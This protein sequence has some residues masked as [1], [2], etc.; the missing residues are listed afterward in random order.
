MRPASARDYDVYTIRFPMQLRVHG[1]GLRQT[2]D[3]QIVEIAVPNDDSRLHP[4]SRR[5]SQ[6]PPC[7]TTTT[8]NGVTDPFVDISRRST[9]VSDRCASGLSRSP[10]SVWSLCV[11]LSSVVTYAAPPPCVGVTPGLGEV[12]AL[13][14]YI[15]QCRSCGPL[16]RRSI[17]AHS[18][19]L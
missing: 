11:P 9:C 5:D 6:P 17:T 16:L 13:S 4:P 15:Y 10:S 3:I 18:Q 1:P 2:P 14:V 8:P 12:A 19:E 7:L